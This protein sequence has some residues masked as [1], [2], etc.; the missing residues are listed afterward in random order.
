MAITKATIPSQL[1]LDAAGRCN[2]SNMTQILVVDDIQE[3]I[4]LLSFELE[5]DGFDVVAAKSGQECLDIVSQNKPNLILLDIRMP[6]ISGI[7]TLERLKA[8]EDTQDIPVIMVSANNSDENIVNALDLGAHDFV[9]KPI[10]YPILAARIRSALRLSQALIDIEFA[11]TE[12]E[13][14]ATTD[15]LTECYNRRHFFSVA[16][17][18][19]AKGKRF[20]RAISV[21][22]IDIDHFKSIN[23]TH[24][25]ASGDIALRE[26]ARAC[27]LLCRGSDIISRLGGEEFAIC[28]PDTDIHAAGIV[29]ERVRKTCEELDV[30]LEEQSISFTVSIGVTQ[31]RDDDDFD[32]ALNRADALLYKA[33]R[34]GRNRVVSDK[35]A[36]P[37]S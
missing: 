36:P 24:G 15:S 7:E 30:E 20:S 12:L 10:E 18:E 4:T 16:E 14:I 35:E 22:M 28:C 25:H 17:K 23:D 34:A 13:R 32:K 19:A 37:T 33:K 11:N 27:Q 26:F 2:L 21:L 5:D 29:A 31:L 3:N 6:G 8:N 1:L 9:S